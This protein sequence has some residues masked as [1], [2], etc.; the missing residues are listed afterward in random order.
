MRAA[1][2]LA[3]E[4]R[5]PGT[6]P[7]SG[8]VPPAP[9]GYSRTPLP[10]KLGIRPDDVVVLMGAPPEFENTLGDLPSG[11]QLRRDLRRPAHIGLFFVTERRALERV[12]PKLVAVLDGGGGAWVAWPKR[13]SKVPTDVTEDVVREIALREGLVDI[14]VCAID[15]TWSGLKLVRRKQ[16]RRGDEPPLAPRKRGARQG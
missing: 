2:R 1:R 16:N 10:R 8:P 14:K 3:G 13:A 5:R 12:L 7:P 6:H 4:V 15:A 9:A 11:V